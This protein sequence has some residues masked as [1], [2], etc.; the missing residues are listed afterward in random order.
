[1]GPH[2]PSKPQHA[3]FCHATINYG[4][5]QQFANSPDASPKRENTGIK[6]IQ[7]IVSALIYYGRA[8][9]NNLLVD[10]SITIGGNRITFPGD[11]G[12][13]TTSLELAKLV[14]DSVLLRPGAKFTTF[15][16]CNSR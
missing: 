3:P 2:H 7:A 14:F 5:K 16:I 1:M 4:A 15:E 8:V 13:P 9:D 11:V 12:T 6:Q 10:L